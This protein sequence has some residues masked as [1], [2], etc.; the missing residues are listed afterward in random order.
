MLTKND[1]NAVPD[2]VK[3]TIANLPADEQAA[4]EA[5]YLADVRRPRQIDFLFSLSLT[6]TRCLT[7]ERF[8]VET[9]PGGLPGSDHYGVLNTYTYR[10]EPC[11]RADQPAAP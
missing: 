9:A 10:H 8:G 11:P 7:Q 2:E 3:R 5:A 1:V 4:I 6:P